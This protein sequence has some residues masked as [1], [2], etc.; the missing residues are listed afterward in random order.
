[1]PLLPGVVQATSNRKDIKI[2]SHQFRAL[3]GHCVLTRALA[4]DCLKQYTTPYALVLAAPIR[5]VPF[6]NSVTHFSYFT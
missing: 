3:C 1:M 6:E 5:C 4:A 2:C